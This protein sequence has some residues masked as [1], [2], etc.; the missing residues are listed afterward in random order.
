[1][2]R[3]IVKG[4]IANID[5][6]ILDILCLEI[7]FFI[8]YTVRN[9]YPRGGFSEQYQSMIWAIIFVSLLAVFF[10]NS[11]HKIIQRG[12]IAE[13]KQTLLHCA[14]V[15]IGLIVW[16]F[17]FKESSSYSRA[18]VLSMYPGGVCLMAVVRI[19]WKRVSYMRIRKKR[20]LRRVLVVSLANRIE[21]TIERLLQPCRD[22]ELTACSVFDIFEKEK[23]SGTPP[24]YAAPD[25]QY[26]AVKGV[27]VAADKEHIVK[28]VQDNIIDEVFIDLPGQEEEAE[29]LMNIFVSMGLVAHVNLARFTDKV[30][31]KRVQKF[32]GFMVL[33]SG[34]KFVT[35]RQMFLKR[36]MDI[37]GSLAGLIITGMVFIAVAPAIKA[38]SQGTVL[39]SQE[40]VGRNGRRFRIYKFRTMYPD[41]EQKKEELRAKNKMKGLMFKIDDDPRVIPIG[42]FLRERGI[43][44]FPQFWNVLR[45]DMS[46]VGT[47]PPTVDEYERYEIRHCKRLAM[48]PGLTGM[49]QTSNRN[50]INDFEDVVALDARYIAEWTLGM[51]FKII[52]KTLLFVLGRKRRE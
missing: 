15:T 13:I 8:S 2:Y 32:A 47:R 9:G 11:Y 20:E 17:I 27:R 39:F 44:E 28:Y 16:M 19:C 22:Y 21:N 42:H 50:D 10:E 24:L 1:M 4:W 3:N 48:R 46:M 29:K 43:D 35:S 14:F 7:A 26:E 52:C 18:I 40:R 31:N 36:L 25:K 34:M 6:T 45:G 41:A 30:E 23:P 33:S 37:I 5:F 12:N 51:D 38:Q 49:W